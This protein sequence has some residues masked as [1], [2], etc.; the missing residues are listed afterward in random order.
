[1]L[2]PITMMSNQGGVP[3]C[4]IWNYKWVT[5]SLI[6]TWTSRSSHNVVT[7]WQCVTVCAVCSPFQLVP[8]SWFP[9]PYFPSPSCSPSTLPSPSIEITTRIHIDNPIPLFFAQ[10]KSMSTMHVPEVDPTTRPW[11]DSLWLEVRHLWFLASHTSH[12][13]QYNH[14]SHAICWLEQIAT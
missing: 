11:F 10:H 4:Q 3:S 8:E 5:V 9:I 13:P 12:F 1:M 6:V 14:F 2:Y 7:L